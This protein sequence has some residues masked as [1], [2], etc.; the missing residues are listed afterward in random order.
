MGAASDGRRVYRFGGGTAD[1]DDSM[2]TLL[3]GKGA[4]LAS[5]ARLGAPVP[6]GFT[7]TTEVGLA[8]SRG[9][10]P[11]LEA[12]LDAAL[13]WVE[14]VSG[15]RFGDPA[16]PLLLSVRSGARVS[17]PGMM[18]TVLD[19]GLNEA[20]VEGLARTRG[21]ARFAWDAYR[22]LVSMY[23]EVVLGV[24]GEVFEQRLAEARTRA[25]VERDAEL[26]AAQLEAVARAGVDAIARFGTSAFPA[27][28]RDQ[29]RGAIDAVYDSWDGDRAVA[30]RQLERIPD[31]WGTAVNVQAMVYGNLGDDSGSGVAFTRNPSTGEPGL[32]GEFLVNAQ[33]EDVVAGVRTPLPVRP[34]MEASFPRAAAELTRWAETIERH[35]GDMQD[36]EFTIERGALWILQTRTGK[37]TAAA[38]VRIAT[39]LVAEGLIDRETALRRVDPSRLEQLL[40]ARFVAG[41]DRVVLAT[42]LPAS[43]GAAVGR[44]TFDAEEAVR[45][46]RA[47]QHVVLVRR[48]TSAEDI[49]GLAA[50]RGVLTAR[51]GQTSHAA[52]VARG[53]GRPCVV[54]CDALTISGRA[55]VF[56][57]PS[58]RVVVQAGA[59]LSIDG[60]TGEVFQGRQPTEPGVEGPELERLL[61]WA[62]AVRRLEV[63]VNADTAADAALARRLGAEGVGLCRTEHMFFAQERLPIVRRLVLAADDEA[64]GAALAELLPAQRVDFEDI[65]RA[66]APLPVVIRLLDPPLHEFLPR[67][68]ADI[69][70]VAAALSVSPAEVRARAESLGEANPM[71]G[72]RGCRLGIGHPA[73][74]DHQV[75]AA[76]EAAAAVRA[77]GLEVRL[78]IM[79]PLVA[80]P[81]EL[82][83]LRARIDTLAAEVAPGVPYRVGTMVELPAAALAARALAADAQFFSFGTN[84]LT[85]TTLGLSRDDAGEVLTTYRRL[86]ILP[87]DPFVTLAPAVRELVALAVDRGRKG[88]AD[89]ELGLCGEHG[90]DPDSVRFCHEAG[91]DYVSCSPFRVPAAR[92]AAARAA[93]A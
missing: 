3:G 40:H 27:D 72:N 23:G 28:P 71:L 12:E 13:A 37:R 44:V 26:T 45:R 83:W 49:R 86:G 35:F 67:T 78:G 59:Y 53:M 88:R 62:D 9:V 47:G 6:P 46:A 73:I 75:R 10:D 52:V 79:V 31:G 65:F 69:A 81:A 24:D 93:L 68:E 21:D 30:Y 56:D 19:L 18:E 39:E 34:D 50:C 43:P 77:D 42:G 63:H 66:M 51:G 55:C 36:L 14:E 17:M 64:R 48:D 22:R 38:E 70:R 74:Y 84:D 41:G 60:A 82:A 25:G 7:L 54:G 57:G 58:G 29:L 4:G 20:V 91:L 89:L 32:Y 90:G 87:A 80:V 33:G 15:A 92:L 76:L 16:R 5:L 8:R 11:R 61:G 85:Q 2:R 1:G